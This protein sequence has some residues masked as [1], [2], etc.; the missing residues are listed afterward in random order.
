MKHRIVPILLLA[1]F[2]D[3]LVMLSLDVS[4][5]SFNTWF[6]APSGASHHFATKSSKC[7]LNQANG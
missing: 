1:V 6:I 4:V 7:G 2:Q 3:L 5:A